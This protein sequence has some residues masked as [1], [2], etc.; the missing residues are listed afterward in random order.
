MLEFCRKLPGLVITVSFWKK[1]LLLVF[2]IFDMNM[3]RLENNIEAIIKP[4]TEIRD[5]RGLLFDCHCVGTNVD[6]FAY[7]VK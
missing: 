1:L 4:L 2:V 5:A 3:V 6:C 7:I